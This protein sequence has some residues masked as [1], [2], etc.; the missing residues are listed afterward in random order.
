[1]T[2]NPITLRDAAA[3]N[4]ADTVKQLLQAGASIDEFDGAAL[5]AALRHKH[6]NIVRILLDASADC[7]SNS[8]E[9]MRIAASH[10]D[11]ASLQCLIDHT[12]T[13]PFKPGGLD[14]YLDQAILS[15]DTQ[16]V[17]VLLAA[18]ADPKAGNQHPVKTA[19][20]VGSVEILRILHQNGADLCANGSQSLFNAVSGGHAE[21]VRFLLS[22]GADPNSRRFKIIQMAIANGD[23][24]ILETLLKAGGIIAPPSVI[25]C[26]AEKDSL[27]TLLFMIALGHP[28]QPHVDLI[29]EMAVKEGAVKILTHTLKNSKVS[30]KVLDDGLEIAARNSSFRIIE[31]LALY[32]ADA[33][34][35]HSAALKTVIEAHDFS[36][37]RLLLEAKAQVADLDS[38]SVAHVI[39]GR[40]WQFLTTLLQLGVT[41]AGLS[42]D[43]EPAAELLNVI[44][45]YL[46][47]RDGAGNFLPKKIRDERHKFIKIIAKSL[48]G[49]PTFTGKTELA[50]WL[51]MFY[52]EIQASAIDDRQ[53]GLLPTRQN[54]P[55]AIPPPW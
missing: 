43:G 23:A 14:C 5:R 8:A 40:D 42:L 50:Y 3:Q 45:P 10:G 6:P 18:G 51:T 33:S 54:A 31:L 38:N 1:M 39:N 35:N 47:L 25:A 34:T 12:K 29:A 20:S 4:D 32:R 26:A 55:P 11:A 2:P 44:H 15:R 27:E 9:F 49:H 19:A 21:A 48:K 52:T 28:F 53:T 17:Q 41:V 22:E 7:Q 16:S 37:A 30:Q 46:I 24:E 36:L 13:P